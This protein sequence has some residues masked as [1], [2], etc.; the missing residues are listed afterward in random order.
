MST[1][2]DLV[3]AKPN[4]YDAAIACFTHRDIDREAH[5]LTFHFADGSKLKFKITYTLMVE[6]GIE[7]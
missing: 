3:R 4:Q 5:T 6:E 7:R 1:I 2:A